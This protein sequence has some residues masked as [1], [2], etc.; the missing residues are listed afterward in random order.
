MIRTA[1][2]RSAMTL[3]DLGRAAG[4]SHS[5]IAAY[6]AGRKEPSVDTFARLLRA[7]GF[8]LDRHLVPAVGG[9]DRTARGRELEAVLDLA[10]QF[11]ARHAERLEAPIFGR[12]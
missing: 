7:A 8:E 12:T 10:A 3:R 6:E 2:L 11:P 1:R 4:T 5:A 9:P